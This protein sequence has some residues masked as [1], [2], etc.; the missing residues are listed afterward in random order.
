MEEADLIATEC[1]GADKVPRAIIWNQEY[2]F[3]CLLA[4]PLLRDR[5][6]ANN[7]HPSLLSES[8]FPEQ[9]HALERWL[10]NNPDPRF[11]GQF[12]SGEIEG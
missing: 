8:P 12:L 9:M 10:A 2:H 1:D 5:V 3:C 4:L 11:N 7:S 6:L